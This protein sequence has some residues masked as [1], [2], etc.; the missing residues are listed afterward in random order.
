VATADLPDDGDAAALLR[1]ALGR[2]ATG[3]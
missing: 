1:Q 2:L 3:A